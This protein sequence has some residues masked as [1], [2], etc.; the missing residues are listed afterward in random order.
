[1]AGRPFRVALL[2]AFA[3]AIVLLAGCTTPFAPFDG[4]DGD[5]AD[6]GSPT[7]GTQSDASTTGNPWDAAELTVAVVDETGSDRDYVPLVERAAAFWNGNATAYGG[8]DVAFVVADD[9]HDTENADVV[10]RV[11]EQI[12]ECGPEAHTA[13]CAPYVTDG[14]VRRPVDVRVV[15]GLSDDSA[16]TVL[17]HE[18]GHLLGLDHDDEPQSVMRAQAVLTTEPQPDATDRALPWNNATLAVYVDDANVSAR[19][20]AARSEQVGHALDYVDRGADG[21]VPTNVSF[22]RTDDRD[23]ADLVVVF[24]DE[25]ACRGDAVSCFTARGVDPD[26]DGALETYVNATI[27]VRTDVDADAVG[28][29]VGRWTVRALGV[30]GDEYPEPLRSDASYTERRSEWWR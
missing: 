4:A 20:R 1:M 24:A 19:D 16:V 9:P 26:G 18:F 14:P 6:G 7:V 5:G 10:V 25:S 3:A 22:V 30:T 29:H 23:V 11:V 12:A 13:G 17:R 8:H 21:S 15:G 28:W 27:T 2:P